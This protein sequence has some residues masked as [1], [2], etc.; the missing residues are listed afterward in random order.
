MDSHKGYRCLAIQTSFMR[1]LEGII[2]MN[3][4]RK[5]IHTNQFKNQAG[6]TANKSTRDHILRLWEIIEQVNTEGKNIFIC[7]LDVAGAYDGIS[8]E[9]LL[10]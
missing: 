3:I 2:M 4:D 8:H 7:G 6:F 5:K 10:E 9:V 1:I